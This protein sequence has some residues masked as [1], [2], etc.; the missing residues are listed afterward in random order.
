[1]REKDL[2]AVKKLYEKVSEEVGQVIVGMKDVIEILFL[3]L[4]S[5]GHVLLEGTPGLAKTYLAR[6]FA[7]TLDLEFKRVQ[8]TSDMLPSDVNGSLIYNKRDDKFEFRKGPVFAHIV[9]ADEINRAPPRTQSALLEAMQEKQVTVEGIGHLL[10]NPFMVVATQNPIE[11]EGTYPLPEAELDRFEFRVYLR[12]LEMDQEIEMLQKK[13]ERGENIEVSK[14]GSEASLAQASR[15]VQ[16]IS[17]E[18]SVMDYIA[19]IVSATRADSRILL[20]ASPRALISLL[21]ASKAKAALEGRDYV[22]PDD[23][24]SLAVHVLNHR[25]IVKPEVAAKAA[26]TG[27]V[28]THD[29]VED[30]VKE[31]ISAVEVPR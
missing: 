26:G 31:I 2:D 12:F 22:I 25:L 23:P 16:G 6:T 24:K 3:G 11:Q 13:Q 17:V 5:G 29:L 1:M 9:L 21:Y 7:N 14:V 10:P 28:W 19:R 27:E 15:T 4:L 30:I 8:F 18:T 20:G